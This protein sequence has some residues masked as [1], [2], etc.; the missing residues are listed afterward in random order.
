MNNQPVIEVE[1]LG[2]VYRDGWL[3]RRRL[4]VLREVTLDVRPGEI[5]G[6]L[7]P[8]GAGKTTFIKIL[9][10]IVRKWTG[11]ARLL[12]LPAGDRRSRR[13]VGFLPENLR[14]ARHHTAATAL[15]YY[16]KLNGVPARQIRERSGELLQ[17][18]GLADRAR[19]SVAK[20]SKGM[21]QRLGLAQALLHDPQLV[22]LDEPT[23][24][25]DPVGRAHVR[26]I[27]QQLKAQGK[28]VFLNSHLLQE[29]ELICDRI[30]ILDKG[31]LRR[32]GPIQEI[33]SSG[34]GKLLVSK[35]EPDLVLELAG[36]EAAIRA[37]LA[38]ATVAAWERPAAGVVR[39]VLKSL[40]QADADGCVDRLRKHG[41][42]LLGLGRVRRSL[43][44]AFLAIVAGPAEGTCA[45]TS[46]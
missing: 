19:D 24:G 42:S 28:T 41:V 37:A 15:D 27:M 25:L 2:K 11:S 1:S 26:S 8:N 18:V 32:I 31:V 34:V 10:G 38:G 44:D 7:G 3:R 30:A 23:D 20:Y 21:L 14:I 36:D 39:V 33:T 29:V 17:L 46:Q 40:S 9:L 35:V 16:G 5:F 4:E 45:P 6:L 22:I 13:R 12:G 43:E